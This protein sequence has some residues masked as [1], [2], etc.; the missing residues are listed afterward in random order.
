MNRLVAH[1]GLLAVWAVSFVLPGHA[2]PKVSRGKAIYEA[3][4]LV[5][6]GADGTGAMPGVSDLTAADGP[7]SKSDDVL[8]RSL[9]TGINSRGSSIA[10]PPRG[11]NPKLTDDDLRVVVQYLRSA[12]GAGPR[13]RK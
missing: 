8:F 5:C 12:F 2:E 10:M 9:V 6:H 13:G 7:L 1:S 11:G 4:C 3:S